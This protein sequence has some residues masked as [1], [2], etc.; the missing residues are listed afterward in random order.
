M[1]HHCEL[2]SWPYI[3]KNPKK[4]KQSRV[5]LLTVVDIP[6]D[7]FANFHD[8]IP[9]QYANLVLNFKYAKMHGYDM[10]VVQVNSSEYRMNSTLNEPPYKFQQEELPSLYFVLRMTS[11]DPSNYDFVLYLDQTLSMSVRWQ[12]RSIDDFIEHWDRSKFTWQYGVQPKN[13]SILMFNTGFNQEFSSPNA[14]LLRSSSPK[15]STFIQDW[16][17]ES[18][19]IGSSREAEENVALHHMITRRNEIRNH[20]AYF[21]SESVNWPCDLY[22][23]ICK[24][25]NVSEHSEFLNS[26]ISNDLGMDRI[27]FSA[28]LSEISRYH[29][30]NLRQ[31]DLLDFIRNSPAFDIDEKELKL[32]WNRFKSQVSLSSSNVL[33]SKSFVTAILSKRKQDS[34]HKF[35]VNSFIYG[36]DFLFQDI[37]ISESKVFFIS[38]PTA[39]FHNKEEMEKSILAHLYVAGTFVPMF[40]NVTCHFNDIM[41]SN[42]IGELTHPDLENT[43]LRDS[44]LNISVKFRDS[45][46]D[47]ILYSDRPQI[48]ENDNQFNVTIFTMFKTDDAVSVDSFVQY[49]QQLGVENF[50]FYIHGFLSQFP[51]VKELAKMYT[52]KGTSVTFA[53]WNFQPYWIHSPL[54][55]PLMGIHNAQ[56]TAMNS[57]LYRSRDWTKWLGFFDLD[58]Y[59][60][61]TSTKG[62]LKNKLDYTSMLENITTVMFN[63]A[64]AYINKSIVSSFTLNE[65][66]SADVIFE[67]NLKSRVVT[68][69]FVR[70][71]A[72]ANV[73]VHQP[74]ELIAGVIEQ[75]ASTNFYLHFGFEHPGRSKESIVSPAVIKGIDFVGFNATSM[76]ASSSSRLNLPSLS[77]TDNSSTDTSFLEPTI[78]EF[79]SPYD[80]R[81]VKFEDTSDRQIYLFL[82][83]VLYP[84]S[85]PDTLN[86]LGFDLGE[87]CYLRAS[88]FKNKDGSLPIREKLDM[89]GNRTKVAELKS[90]SLEARLRPNFQFR[91]PRKYS[92]TA[93]EIR[94]NIAKFTD[95]AISANRGRGACENK[96][97]I[98]MLEHPYGRF[99]NGLVEWKNA[100]MIT[101]Y[102][103]RTFVIPKW[104]EKY[105]LPFNLTKL[106]SH[107][108]IISYD[109]YNK[110]HFTG[111][112]ESIEPNQALDGSIIW[113]NNLYSDF[114]KL[115]PRLDENV[116]EIIEKI[117]LK[118]LLFV[119]PHS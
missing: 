11:R 24:L 113:T 13:A 55:S 1:I 67:N 111:Y 60:F 78:E 74:S 93:A 64:D 114:N 41:A 72:I 97:F 57:V 79:K 66:A 63:G 8:D 17:N 48:I 15:L 19:S 82:D 94:R 34:I 107:L 99:G 18:I 87:L 75:N 25:D 42:I 96:D 23:W 91:L 6:I 70:P 110:N 20:L 39:N 102:L 115:L 118:V 88:Y 40:V 21:K 83:K 62:C 112:I 3:S 31:I 12:R 36:S 50:I 5:L 90:K 69:Y 9:Y 108:C 27:Q 89:Y 26:A 30:V 28:A 81:I 71:S 52:R 4:S 10:L 73:I 117:S 53:E 65:I 45:H 68:K 49:Y 44:Y 46:K 58:E 76:F 33:I 101:D 56:V 22:G 77:G 105:L 32:T 59:V 14:L 109:E 35:A 29:T 106:Q 92:E 51:K 80:G 61:L 43:L 54:V 16:W 103:N 104:L 116:L 47:F 119:I 100:M 37:F 86:D 98:T 7:E 95:F 38:V 85:N 84:I 2:E